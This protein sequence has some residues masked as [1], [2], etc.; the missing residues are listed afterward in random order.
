MKNTKLGFAVLP[1]II[2]ILILLGG[3]VYFYTKKTVPE[4][5]SPETVTTTP[6]VSAPDNS[7]TLPAPSATD[8]T[9]DW[10]TYK[11]EKYGFE[12]KYPNTF[13]PFSMKND[14]SL[15]TIGRTINIQHC[16]EKPTCMPTTENPVIS[17]SISDLPY[18]SNGY[19]GASVI[20]DGD[21]I[22]SYIEGVEGEGNI[23]YTVPVGT[24]HLVIR[25]SYID[26]R[27]VGIYQGK[28]NFWN[29]ATQKNITQQILSTFRFT[30]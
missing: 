18:V 29:F 30:E 3:G 4:V 10:K 16:T 22:P 24:K 9:K 1:I 15:V 14:P 6:T 17:V 26:E 11:N 23:I 28:A 8:E 25:Q 7:K 5:M 27:V 19:P 13:F 21:N 12:F 2:V 20:V